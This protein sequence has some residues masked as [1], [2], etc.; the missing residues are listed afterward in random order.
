[1][2][3]GMSGRWLKL[4]LAVSLALNLAVI[5]LVG[6]VL[7]HRRDV[8]QAVSPDAGRGLFGMVAVL[9]PERREALRA[10]LGGPPDL[11]AMVGQWAAFRAALR[12]PEVGAAELESILAGIR[13]DQGAMAARLE[14]ALS[15]QLSAMPFE[16]RTAYVARLERFRPGSRHH[17]EH[18]PR[19]DAGGWRDGPPPDGRGGPRGPDGPADGPT[20]GPYRGPGDRPAPPQ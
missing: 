4:A 11:A 16:D 18:V 12:Q 3:G 20:G 19:D 10:D 1:M 13:E 14:A 7:M 9:P 2:R 17:G 15:A 6:G 5:G 8:A